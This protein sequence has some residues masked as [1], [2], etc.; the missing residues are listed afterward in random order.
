[1]LSWKPRIEEEPPVDDHE[2][3]IRTAKDAVRHRVWTTLEQHGVVEPGVAGRIP[4]FTGAA[5][6]A[7]RLTSLPAWQNARR[8]KA[9]P[10]RAQLPARIHALASGKTVYMAVPRLTSLHPFYLLDPAVLPVP[11]AQAASHEAAATYADTVPVEQVPHLD[12]VIC[13]SVAVNPDGVR[14]GKGAGY[15]DIELGLLTE[16]GAITDATTI[17][18]T[19][20]S[21][22]IID[23][24]LPETQ[25][26]VRVDAIITADT[27]ISCPRT[28]R[29]GGI[30]WSHLSADKIAAIP[31][32][33]VR[34]AGGDDGA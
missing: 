22:Q 10:D 3:G 27:I 16:V 12:L 6:A 24:P 4:A 7:D 2:N 20:H 25:H 21:L 32:L 14:I 33:A 23:E 30:L 15:A 8:I 13:G 29:P 31:A 11:A 28:R 34:A 26:D 17:V 1:M 9:N 5:A 19:V 18:T